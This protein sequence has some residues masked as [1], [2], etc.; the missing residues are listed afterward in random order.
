MEES[1]FQQ[2]LRPVLRAIVD[3]NDFP[4]LDRR[5]ANCFD[6]LF[7]R[8]LFIVTGN[9]D[10]DLHLFN[11]RGIRRDYATSLE[12]KSGYSQLKIQHSSSE[13]LRKLSKPVV[14]ASTI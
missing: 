5:V 9:Y 3:H 14:R 7:N 4:A 1:L 8:I 2:R 6:D 11:P 12:K 10:G 13:C